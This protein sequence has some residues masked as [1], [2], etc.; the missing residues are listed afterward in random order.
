M[1]TL[2]FDTWFMRKFLGYNSRYVTPPKTICELGRVILGMSFLWL[3][4]TTVALAVVSLY[5][6]GLFG[7]FYVLFTDATLAEFFDFAVK[8]ATWTGVAWLFFLLGNFALAVAGGI[9]AINFA[10]E[11]RKEKRDEVARLNF[12]KTGE[13]EVPKTAPSPIKEFFKG[14]WARFH[15]KTCTMIQWE[16]DPATLR[17][18]EYEQ[19]ER[20]WEAYR[21][22]LI[23]ETAKLITETSS[24][25]QTNA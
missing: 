10:K 24:D 17:Q 12:E 16:N 4:V 1:L 8:E 9:F 25:S 5:L 13:W 11:Y 21:A 3:V 22:K 19:E 18:R 14:V 23:T 2:N 20:E 6:T 15:D 7:V